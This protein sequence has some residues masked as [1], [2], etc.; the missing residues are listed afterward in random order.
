[1]KHGARST[2]HGAW[3]ATMGLWL[4]RL[5]LVIDTDNGG[6]LATVNLMICSMQ[7][8]AH[9]LLRPGPMLIAARHWCFSLFPFMPRLCHW[10]RY[11]PFYPSTP[12][13]IEGISQVR[14]SQEGAN[15]SSCRQSTSR[16]CT[17]VHAGAEL[18]FPNISYQVD[19]R[20]A[21]EYLGYYPRKPCTFLVPT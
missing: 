13:R 21:L 15:A 19:T 11:L 20:Q 6:I 9:N 3:S 1:M 14:G 2:G 8:N 7:F 17:G 4:P 12:L 18:T 5:M 10:W 16:T